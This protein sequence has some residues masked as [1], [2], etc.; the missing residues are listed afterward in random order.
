[1]ENEN[2]KQIN[3]SQIKEKDDDM[4]NYY[5]DLSSNQKYIDNNKNK[6]PYQKYIP[7]NKNKS[8]Y[9]SDSTKNIPQDKYIKSQ[10]QD[11]END[12]II[13][14]NKLTFDKDIST[15]INEN[16][17][18]PSYINDDKYNF[19]NE[20]TINN[21]PN[22]NDINES[23]KYN[24]NY[25]DYSNKDY[26]KISD[27]DE[28]SNKYN[29][30][31]QNNNIN[32][33]KEISKKSIKNIY[34]ID[35]ED[36]PRNI[37]KSITTL[38]KNTKI[39]TRT[40][41]NNRDI[42]KNI[43]EHDISNN[44][45][46]ENIYDSN[47]TPFN[48]YDNKKIPTNYFSNEDEDDKIS[49]S[50]KDN[51]NK[52]IFPNYQNPDKDIYNYNKK[53]NVLPTKKTYYSNNKNQFNYNPKYQ[54]N[55]TNNYNINKKP[56]QDI[57][58]LN[59][60]DLQNKKE[61]KFNNFDRINQIKGSNR[62][63]EISSDRSEKSLVDTGKNS[64]INYD[65]ENEDKF[66]PYSNKF[67]NE[68]LDK[69]N[70]R[71]N[72]KVNYNYFDPNSIRYKK[73]ET[74]NNY[75]TY[76]NY[77]ET[78]FDSPNKFYGKDFDYSIEDP[79]K[80][81]IDKDSTIL[82]KNSLTERYTDEN[83]TIK[84][85]NKKNDNYRKSISNRDFDKIPSSSNRNSNFD[86]INKNTILSS[87][88]SN[89]STRYQFSNR[90]QF[91]NRFQFS[92]RNQ[93]SNRPNINQYVNRDIL[94]KGY[95][96]PQKSSYI[97]MNRTPVPRNYQKNSIRKNLMSPNNNYSNFLNDNMRKSPKNIY[98][99]SLDTSGNQNERPN[100]KSL[101]IDSYSQTDNNDF[102]NDNNKNK[103]LNPQFIGNQNQQMNINSNQLN[104]IKLLNEIDKSNYNLK[105]E[106][107]KEKNNK[108]Y[109]FNYECNPPINNTYNYN[110]CDNY[111]RN[112]EI[113]KYN[114][115]NS[116]NQNSLNNMSN[117]S[118]NFY[119]NPYRQQNINQYG[120]SNNS[121]FNLD[122]MNMRAPIRRSNNICYCPNCGRCHYICDYSYY[123]NCGNY[124]NQNFT[125][126]Y[127][128]NSYYY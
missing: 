106:L 69:N 72:N 99:S 100:I 36:L 52:K 1:M 62:I 127:Y 80:R 84:P 16:N 114:R 45:K 56:Y 51:S 79:K 122:N 107:E 37:K 38:D 48:E 46:N 117:I 76:P 42:N 57:N 3:P 5:K 119:Y 10:F 54:I 95:G 116:Y 8:S 18:K 101:S 113:L 39:K 12:N 85:P 93:I 29:L 111:N 11:E 32:Q 20:N 22:L 50:L 81:K 44:E 74:G 87:D 89:I 66:V 77:Q 78:D 121:S 83:K 104:P 27:D 47:K 43:I 90:N 98:L 88:R 13:S 61:M 34:D 86:N 19:N 60:K 68:I 115:P 35:E 108:K 6:I 105:Q 120:S 7:D 92:N 124:S 97:Q 71:D 28:N 63:N 30:P 9:Q 70:K 26:N 41:Q 21:K 91:S 14:N 17:N 103:L 25:D 96:L 109:N 67:L 40:F 126:G 15:K 65:E 125:S 123:D 73:N 112:Q 102:E 128:N 118:N 33:N 2:I 110:Y 94:N 64:R 58:K 53:S 31:Y 75:E 24:K 23:S 4:D 49:S 55:E 59:D 82:H